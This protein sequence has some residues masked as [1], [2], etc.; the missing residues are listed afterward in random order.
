MEMEIVGKL[1]KVGDGYYI[2]IPVEVHNDWKARLLENVDVVTVDYD[3]QNDELI[4]YPYQL[5]FPG[6][7]RKLIQRG[8][9][10]IL[11]VPKRVGEMWSSRGV[12]Y[13]RKLYFE[14]DLKFV[15]KPM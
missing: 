8:T 7:V 2:T 13:L 6:D 10:H 14:K 15:V 12:V 11:T 4:I 5:K 3:E 9:T 1:I